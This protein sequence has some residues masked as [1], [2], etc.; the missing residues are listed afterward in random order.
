ML[1]ADVQ[2]NSNHEIEPSAK[3]P[4]IARNG[5]AEVSKA[6]VEVNRTRD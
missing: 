5:G 6:A 3:F 1:R 4:E 2:V